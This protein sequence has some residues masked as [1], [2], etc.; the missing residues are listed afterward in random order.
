MASI[1]SSRFRRSSGVAWS[2]G[3]CDVSQSR[4]VH[5]QQAHA[6]TQTHSRK[7]SR[8]NPLV[9]K[10]WYFVPVKTS[11][12]H[13]LSGRVV[14][15]ASLPPTKNQELLS[16]KK[17]FADSRKTQEKVRQIFVCEVQKLLSTKVLLPTKK[18]FEGISLP[19]TFLTG[20]VAADGLQE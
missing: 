3:H 1:S 9:V 5:R 11:S 14:W 13:I 7:Y 12:Q 17:N 10:R 2:A 16:C 4:A 8:T 20:N 6:S 18:S 19:D 15:K